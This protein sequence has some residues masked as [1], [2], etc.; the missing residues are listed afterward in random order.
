MRL[1][2]ETTSLDQATICTWPATMSSAKRHQF[3]RMLLEEDMENPYADNCTAHPTRLR[4]NPQLT[5]E[6]SFESTARPTR[7]TQNRQPASGDS[8][9]DF[10]R[11]NPY[12]DNLNGA[13]GLANIDEDR[14]IDLDQS[15]ATTN[16]DFSFVSLKANF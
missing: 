4:Q 16:Q 2:V 10:I 12:A 1:L 5:S 15:D 14:S 3:Q 13:P 9:E 6:D 8:F 7:L 11:G